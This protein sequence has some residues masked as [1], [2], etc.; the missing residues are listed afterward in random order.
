VDVDEFERDGGR[1]S[2]AVR[3]ADR[4]GIRL[5]VS[6][7]CFEYWLLLHHADCAA[8]NLSCGPVVDRLRQHVPAYDK[9]VLGFADFADG[10]LAA[11]D[12]ARRRDPSG[13][14][15]RLNPSTGVWTLATRMREQTP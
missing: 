11:I 5:A 10:V 4:A 15:H 2:A 6:N 3:L 1:I 12:R 13:T 9:T 7:P 8:P 14:D